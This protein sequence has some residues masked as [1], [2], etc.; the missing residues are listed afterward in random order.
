[1][2]T[3]VGVSVCPC[4][5]LDFD[6]CCLCVCVSLIVLSFR[7]VST[8]WIANPNNNLISNAA[9]GSQVT[10]RSSDGPFRQVEYH[11]LPSWEN[12]EPTARLC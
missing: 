3:R 8:F 9:A 11:R 1:M 4:V 12:V 5:C 10:S 7:A 6:E 2:S